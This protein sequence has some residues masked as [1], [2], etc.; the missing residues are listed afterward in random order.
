VVRPMVAMESSR[1]CRRDSSLNDSDSWSFVGMVLGWFWIWKELVWF[2][3]MRERRVGILS[4][5][6]IA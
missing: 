1:V 5:V 4:T 6:M 3:R 2:I